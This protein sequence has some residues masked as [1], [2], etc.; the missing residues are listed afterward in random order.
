[1]E[2]IPPRFLPC[3]RCSGRLGFVERSGLAG[4]LQLSDYEGLYLVENYPDDMYVGVT[5]DGLFALPLL[6]SDPVSG[7]QEWVHEEGDRFRR[8]REDDTLAEAIIFERD[9][10]G[11]VKSL[12]HHSY[13]SKKVQQ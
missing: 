1:M 6:S 11:R 4:D 13:R 12:M 2:T 3:P 9:D 10:K 8:K 5:K 7:L